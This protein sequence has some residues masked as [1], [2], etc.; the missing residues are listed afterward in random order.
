[1]ATHRPDD[2]KLSRQRQRVAEAAGRLL[3]TGE[4]TDPDRAR[5]KAAEQL[6]VRREAELPSGDEVRAAALAYRRLFVAPDPSPLLRT[7]REAALE[8]MQFLATFQPR[9]AGEVLRDGSDAQ[10]PVCLHL[11]ADNPDDVARFL[12]D[13]RITADQ[14]QRRMRLDRDGSA[15]CP[16]W[17][18]QAGSVAFE[19]LVL[20]RSSLRQAPLDPLD[21]QPQARASVSALTRLLGP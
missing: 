14:G 1:M 10:A 11:H 19:L 8:A 21:G 20:P 7:Q 4:Q 13:H 5:R 6:G 2:P 17:S 3:A 15:D 12:H 16:L 9:L 18:F